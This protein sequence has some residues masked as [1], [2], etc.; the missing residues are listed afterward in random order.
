MRFLFA[1]AAALGIAAVAYGAAASLNVGGG[2]VQ[3]GGATDTCVESISVDYVLTGSN[4]DAIV[5]SGIEDPEC[6]GADV[7]L[8]TNDDDLD[9]V[10]ANFDANDDTISDIATFSATGPVD[11]ATLGSVVVTIANTSQVNANCAAS[12]GGG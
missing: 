9:G 3:S 7:I 8:D 6:D 11:A 12:A 5:V 4:V 10:C 1:I 2:T